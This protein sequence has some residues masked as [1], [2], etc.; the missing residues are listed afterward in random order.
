[1]CANVFQHINVALFDFIGGDQLSLSQSVE[2]EEAKLWQ[3]VW[4][5]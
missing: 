1:M 2:K 4:L 5:T 3:M